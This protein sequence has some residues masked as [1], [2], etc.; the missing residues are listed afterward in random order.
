MLYEVITLHMSSEMLINTGFMVL[1]EQGCAL[2]PDLGPA[3][4]AKVAPPLGFLTALM[5]IWA[6]MLCNK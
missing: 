1:S 5:V 3:C 6:T 2:I 4:L